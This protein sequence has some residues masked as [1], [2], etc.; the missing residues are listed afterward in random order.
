MK[1]E[2]RVQVGAPDVQPNGETVLVIHPENETAQRLEALLEDA[3]FRAISAS[4][5][6]QADD[7]VRGLRFSPP[8]VLLTVLDEETESSPILERMRSKPLGGQIAVVGLGTGRDDER[9]RAL[10]M[11]L[12]HLIPPPYDQEE[13]LLST[14]RA[15]DRQRR[16]H[17]ISGSLSQLSAAELL[18]AV[19]GNRRS[20]VVALESQGR[21]ATV[22]LRE[23]RIIDAETDDEQQGEDAVYTLAVWEEGSF[24]AEFRPVSV[25]ERITTSTTSLLLE[26][27]RRKDEARRNAPPPH[28]AMV[29]P[30]PPPPKALLTLHRAL[31]LLNVATSYAADHLAPTL[32]AR[33][34]ESARQRV[35]EHHALAEHFT[36]SP[37]GQVAFEPGGDGTPEPRPVVDVVAA[38][39]TGLFRDL[40]RALP[41][42]FTFDQLRSASEAVADD[43][44][45]LGF[46]QA[47]DRGSGSEEDP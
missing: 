44:E 43:L 2:A 6:K 17:R 26:A 39:L 3:G 32:V 10:R 24:E 16:D 20:G 21:S 47:L 27:M 36:V 28:A 29:D 42:H 5:H 25:A 23:G 1:A 35:L 22:W 14:C 18:Q 11:G 13:L 38:W 9:R 41:G 34:T 19:E 30:P 15:L 40:E 12:A 37:S 31:T 46:Y 7:E 4:S 8:A 45:S 33:R